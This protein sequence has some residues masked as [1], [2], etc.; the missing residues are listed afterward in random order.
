MSKKIVFWGLEVDIPHYY[1]AIKIQGLFDQFYKTDTRLGKVKNTLL[2]AEFIGDEALL[3]DVKVL[4][5]LIDALEII[6]TNDA[7][8]A[9]GHILGI[10]KRIRQFLFINDKSGLLSGPLQNYFLEF[11]E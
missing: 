5:T 7:F 3:A 10:C 2:L 11:V 4:K 1:D 9:S 6:P 8:D